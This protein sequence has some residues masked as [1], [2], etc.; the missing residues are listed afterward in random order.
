MIKYR[1]SDSARE[2]LENIYRYGL[3][4]FGEQQADRYYFGLATCLERIAENPLLYPA[5][6]Y[7]K[8]GYCRCTYI[9]ERFRPYRASYSLDAIAA[10]CTR[11]Y[12]YLAPLGLYHLCKS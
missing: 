8:P 1:L 4:T 10:G 6:D 9:S 3:Q 5:V 11:G 7:I 2:D 12:L